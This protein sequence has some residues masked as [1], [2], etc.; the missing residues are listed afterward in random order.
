MKIDVVISGCGPSGALLANLLGQAGRSVVVLERADQIY[1]LP[2]AVHFDAEIM[3]VFQG[4]GLAEQMS[5]I[6]GELPGAEFVT[7]DGLAKRF[8]AA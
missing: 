2:R 1:D 5:A 3:R 4:L 6:S 7:A 8:E